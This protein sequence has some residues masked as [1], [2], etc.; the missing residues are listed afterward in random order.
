LS[1]KGI[2]VVN[3]IAYQ[4]LGSVGF[5]IIDVSDPSTP[6][7]IDSFRT[8]G[9]A[10]DLFVQDTFV[11]VADYDSLQ[12]VNVAD[13]SNPF[14]IGSL[15]MPNPCYDVFVS[16]NYAFIA[17]ESFTGN[18]GS[19][20]V[21]DITDPASPSI[22]ASAN[23]IDA[24]PF[25]LYIEGNYAYVAAADHF[26]PTVQGGVRIVD[27]SNPLSPTLVASY[28]TPGDPRGIFTVFPYVY[29]ADQSSFL[30][31]EHM[32]VGVEEVVDNELFP[33]FKLMQNYPNPFYSM[34]TIR[35]LLS[36]PSHI[37]LK[38]FDISG[39]LVKTLFNGFH[40]AGSYT[41]YWDGKNHENK[42]VPSG[43]YYYQL[44]IGPKKIT[45]N[46]IKLGYRISTHGGNNYA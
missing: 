40:E 20:Q 35:Y 36:E 39:R 2:S 13:P 44:K 27:I 8:P 4:P 21:V 17:C 37:S 29:V 28:D 5:W 15:A 16:G 25:D 10:V 22:V 31:L 45:K 18:D 12:I 32:I 43:V 14:Q 42:R 26:L 7:V 38:V 6:T 19:V 41:V 30:I 1:P 46:I 9:I 3:N 33:N 24:D 34:T 11:Y 23:N